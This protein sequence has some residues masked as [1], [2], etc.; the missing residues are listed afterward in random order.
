MGQR[1]RRC[2]INTKS[3]SQTYISF[4]KNLT[5]LKARAKDRPLSLKEILPFFSG[6]GKI[7][8][9]IFFSLPFSQVFG[10]AIPFGFLIAYLGL[11]YAFCAKA[12]LPRFI[13]K[14]KIAPKIL[15][16]VVN[17]LLY[18][19][20]KIA[21]LSHPRH[22]WVCTLP[23]MRKVNG[24]LIALVGIFLAISLPIPLSSYISSAAIIFLGI[25]LLNDDGIL[26]FIAYP[27]ALFY[28]VFVIVTMNYISMREI[29]HKF[30]W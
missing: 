4:K 8:L 18:F 29:F 7:L 27:V 24:C 5:A 16:F 10:L 17:Q 9:L 13:L 12:W 28:I 23:G 19:I 2:F 15:K 6:K 21:K 26:V 3:K 20:K 14:K 11:R 30:F 25:G 22:V 1:R